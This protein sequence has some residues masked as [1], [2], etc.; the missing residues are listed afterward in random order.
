MRMVM[1]KMTKNILHSE[2]MIAY[3]WWERQS[4][5]GDFGVLR[6]RAGLHSLL[7]GTEAYNTNI[8]NL[9]NS[10]LHYFGHCLVFW[11][12]TVRLT[13][14]ILSAFKLRFR[15]ISSHI[16]CS[17]KR[18]QLGC[19]HLQSFRARLILPLNTISQDSFLLIYNLKVWNRLF[20]A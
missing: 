13:S 12:T 3:F 4:K 15:W 19:C 20:K 14:Y 11:Y 5:K 1:L 8:L 7:I 18:Q 16:G 9:C 2:K 17:L 6:Q 10:K